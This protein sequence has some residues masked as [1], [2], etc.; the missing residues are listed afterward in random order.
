MFLYYSVTPLGTRHL[1]GDK[2][3]YG[4]KLHASIQPR[5]TDAIKRTRRFC[6]IQ[7]PSYCTYFPFHVTQ[8]HDKSD[9]TRTILFSVSASYT[10]TV[11]S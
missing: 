5:L 1:H 10:P 4:I 6:E 2:C 3:T 8:C 11:V 9:G 7:F